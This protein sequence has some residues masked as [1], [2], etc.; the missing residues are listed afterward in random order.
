MAITTNHIA[1]FPS[2]GAGH[3]IP[4]VE[5]ARKLLHRHHVSA[6]IIIP[7]AGPLSPAEDTIL[8]TLPPAIN[9]LLLPAVNFDD[10]PPDAM[11]ETRVFLTASR[12]VPSFR[13]AVKSLL[14]SGKKISA[15]VVDLLGT[16]AFEAAFEFKIPPYI[17]VPSTATALSLFLH[18]PELDETVSCEY[19]EVSEKLTIPGCM[20]IHGKDLLDAVQD[21]NN[22]A[23]KFLLY[24]V[25][26]YRMCEGIILNSFLELENGPINFLLKQES[27]NHPTVFP[28]GPLIRV[29]S[30]SAKNSECLRWLDDQPNT[31]V[32]YVSFGS[33][34]SLSHD[35]MIELALGLEMS[36]QRFLWVVRCPNDT[37]SNATYFSILN[38]DDPLAFLPEGFLNRTQGRGLVVPHWAPQVPILAHGSVCA[39]L[40]HCGWNSTLEAV[41]C[42]VP[43]IAW[44]LYAEQKMNALM[45]VEELKVAIRAQ[46]GENGLVGRVEI[47]NIIK[48]LMEGDEGKEISTRMRGLKDAAAD[49]VSEN[50]SSTKLLA[51]L[52]EKWKKTTS[53]Q[54]N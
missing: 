54:C 48:C 29:G 25:K 42:G 20:P 41:V 23:Y 28:I 12:S 11:V 51:Q 22:D 2:P 6:T 39:F 46:V 43:L 14:D 13:N 24:H 21:R 35:Q 15:V 16:D 34:G 1:I 7:T 47:A 33:G 30:E 37:A 32:L 3:L 19:R 38:S 18:L 52:V 5:F 4:L 27:G 53:L 50:G 17:F 8:S 10:L 31:S 9:H 36:N 40:T 45:L 44:P 26:R 49:V